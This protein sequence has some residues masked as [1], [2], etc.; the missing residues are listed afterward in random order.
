MQRGK[1]KSNFKK[2][3]RIFG[4]GGK[5]GELFLIAQNLNLLLK[6]E[7]SPVWRQI[8]TV[9]EAMTDQPPHP[10]TV[11]T[12]L[13]T[14]GPPF[15]WYPGRNLR[16]PKFAIG[17]FN[18]LARKNPVALRIREGK[19][20]M[21]YPRLEAVQAP[22]S[23]MEH[24]LWLLWRFYFQ[25]EGYK[26]LKRCHNCFRWFV[27]DTRNRSKRRCSSNCTWQ[28]WNRDRRRK[29]KQTEE[30]QRKESKHKRKPVRKKKAS[31]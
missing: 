19:D 26:R 27:D 8:E 28:Y 13:L 14:G 6:G 9:V 20:R 23:E 25:D 17:V 12:T 15:H 29:A 2:W 16:L 31:K 4:I 1:T 10:E 5:Y 21:G 11:G 3:T 24:A 22:S 18:R 7:D 30:K